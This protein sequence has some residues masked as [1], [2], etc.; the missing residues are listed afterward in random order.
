MS[1]GK[2]VRRV[3]LGV[4]VLGVAALLPGARAD[5]YNLTFSGCGS[6]CG[7]NPLGSVSVVQ[8]QDLYTVNVT[9]TLAPNEVFANSATGEALGFMLDKA[10]SYVINL[11]SG[12]KAAV[13]QTEAGF[14]V[15][16]NTVDCTV[17]GANSVSFMVIN[18]HG[19]NPT[20]FVANSL[21][22]FAAS[23]IQL[24][25][26]S[27]QVIWT[28]NVGTAPPAGTPLPTLSAV[29][30]GSAAAIPNPEPATY[31]MLGSGLM[32]L[33]FLGRKVAVRR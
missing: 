16:G 10:G 25:D 24:K 19:L 27:G 22:Y 15:F 21:G 1:E 30:G 18:R 28:G 31:L 8:G 14:G 23:D 20:D 12:F 32:G 29:A 2:H 26:S 6:A 5:V 33:A 7:S 4:I 11:S 17:C 3:H 9:A 13:G